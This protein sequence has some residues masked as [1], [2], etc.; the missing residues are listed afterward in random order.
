VSAKTGE[1]VDTAFEYLI[2]KLVE[3]NKSSPSPTKKNTFKLD[4]TVGKNGGKNPK[5]KKQCC[6]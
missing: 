6:E 2:K 5:A 4:D 1:G 3:K